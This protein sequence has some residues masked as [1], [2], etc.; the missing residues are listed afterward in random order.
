MSD[1]IVHILEVRD[2]QQYTFCGI[3]YFIEYNHMVS[4]RDPELFERKGE[5]TCKRC[6]RIQE[7]RNRPEDFEH[8]CVCKRICGHEGPHI[9]RHCGVEIEEELK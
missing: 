8:K 5:P 6:L 3:S 2:G 9:C 4:V 1:K 7:A